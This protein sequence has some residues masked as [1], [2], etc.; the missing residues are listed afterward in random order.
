MLS[1]DDDWTWKEIQ[2]EDCPGWTI[3]LAKRLTGTAVTLLGP[4]GLVSLEFDPEFNKSTLEVC[5]DA[6]HD[7]NVYKHVPIRAFIDFCDISRL[8]MLKCLT[9][10]R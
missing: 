1:N 4:N 8:E 3:Q 10:T 6:P 7:G 9:P 2:V 5:I